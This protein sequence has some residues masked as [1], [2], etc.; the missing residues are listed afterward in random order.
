MQVDRTAAC[1]YEMMISQRQIDEGFVIAAHSK[2]GSRL[3]LLLFERSQDAHWE[4]AVQVTLCCC[5][6]LKQDTCKRPR[7]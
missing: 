2:A 3:K 1:F 4:L 6:V 5:K 7:C